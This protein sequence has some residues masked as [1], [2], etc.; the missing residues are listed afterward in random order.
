MVGGIV[1]ERERST[2]KAST[3]VESAYSTQA[4]LLSGVPSEPECAVIWMLSDMEKLSSHG[5]IKA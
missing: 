4:R 1:A 2:S 3:A 5:K